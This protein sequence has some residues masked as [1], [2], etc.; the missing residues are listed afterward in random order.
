MARGHPRV[1]H[2][3]R[4]GSLLA[5]L[6]AGLLLAAFLQGVQEVSR[7]ALASPIYFEEDFRGCGDGV[8]ITT[9]G[10]THEAV[11]AGTFACDNSEHFPEVEFNG[12]ESFQHRTITSV[13]DTWTS[14]T[15]SI[16]GAS[17]FSLGFAVRFESFGT[18]SFGGAFSFRFRDGGVTAGS[19]GVPGSASADVGDIHTSNNVGTFENTFFQLVLDTWYLI[20]FTINR[21]TDRYGLVINGTVVDA[22]GPLGGT[23]QSMAPAAGAHDID[24]VTI[25]GRSSSQAWVDWIFTDQLTI[26]AIADSEVFTSSR[27]AITATPDASTDVI[28]NLTVRPAFLSIN[29]LTGLITGTPA[30]AGVF[31]VTVRG[32]VS[33]GE[34]LE[35]FILTVVA[36]GL[37]SFGYS[38]ITEDDPCGATYFNTA[39][40]RVRPVPCSDVLLSLDMETIDGSTGELHDFAL[41]ATGTLNHTATRNDVSSVAATFGVGQAFNGS[42]PQN[43]TLNGVVSELGRPESWTAHWWLLLNDDSDNRT[44]WTKWADVD[45]S[46]GWYFEVTGADQMLVSW[47]GTDNHTFAFV[48]PKGGVFPLTVTFDFETGSLTLYSNRTLRESATFLAH[49]ASEAAG[50]IPEIGQAAN[51]TFNFNG[52]LDEFILW[53]RRALTSD[54]VV[55]LQTPFPSPVPLVPALPPATTV[56]TL[57]ALL[58][59]IL[60]V[61]TIIGVIALLGFVTWKFATAGIVRMK[62]LAAKVK[63]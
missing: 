11:G 55:G 27:V 5:L 45:G 4:R 23:T 48:L 60:T 9:L 59:G 30:T 62:E 26:N 24:E 57:D 12:T 8:S 41:D 16:A 6:V 52:T 21:G 35:S 61:A 46:G 22:N 40:G 47:G 17:T 36:R 37:A 39:T 58:P 10:W 29:V 51:T 53:Q 13:I 25:S 34:A 49:G 63:K 28:W 3:Q 54:Q 56:S 32:N 44:L 18:S 2:L 7:F 15:F 38:G 33:T 42:G 50:V 14:P 19:I 43:L 1:R 20:E 31:P